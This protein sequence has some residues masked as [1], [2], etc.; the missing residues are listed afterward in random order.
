MAETFVKAAGKE[1]EEEGSSSKFLRDRTESGRSQ[2]AS[3]N[4]LLETI[5]FHV[6]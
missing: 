4:A 6:H 1:R 2:S 5:E 3:R